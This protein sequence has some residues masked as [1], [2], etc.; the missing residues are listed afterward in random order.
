MCDGGDAKVGGG[1]A[2]AEFHVDDCDTSRLKKSVN[3]WVKQDY[4][5]R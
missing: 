1:S 2:N 5:N 4:Y 3:G